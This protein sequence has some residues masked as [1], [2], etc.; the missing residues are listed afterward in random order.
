MSTDIKN[1]FDHFEA[2][3]EFVDSSPIVSGHINATYLVKTDSDASYVLQ[4]INHIVF[5]RPEDVIANK[6]TVSTHLRN[7]LKDSPESGSGSYVLNFLKSRSGEYLYRDEEGNFW[8]LMD[9]IEN[10]RVY[11]KTP[12]RGIAFEAGLA[13]GRFLALTENLDPA[14]VIETL[15]RF[16]S[17]SLRFEQFDEALHSASEQRKEEAAREIETAQGLRDEMLQLEESIDAG[18]IPVR[19]THNDTKISNAL[20]SNDGKALCVIDLD[21][22]M[23][24]VVHFDFGDAVRT[25]CSSADEDEPDETKIDFSLEYFEAFVEGFVGESGIR[26]SETEIDGLP[27][28]AK[29]MTFIVGLRFLTDFLN[30]DIYFDTKHDQHNLDRARSQFRRVELIGENLENMKEIVVKESMNTRKR[31][32]FR[33]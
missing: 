22:V 11:L 20:F 25:I 18:E 15:P 16:H 13:F 4:R 27:M 9:Y 3:G 30:D 19:V 2:S 26:L 1:I 8:N 7:K 10:S 6:I 33:A 29:F 5:E 23:S 14:D 24:G 32:E 31:L 28:S 12:N 17:M 21:T